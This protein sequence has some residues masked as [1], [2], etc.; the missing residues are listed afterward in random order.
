MA[1]HR[2]FSELTKNFSPERKR[3]IAAKTVEALAKMDR[4]IHIEP[5]LLDWSEWHPWLDIKRHAQQ[6]GVVVP[7]KQSGVYEVKIR[8]A[9]DRLAIGKSADLRMRIKQGLVC[10]KVGHPAGD[11]IR[12]RENVE[13][14]MVRWA[15]TDR[16]A[17]VEEE[18]HMR[19]EGRFGELPKYTHFT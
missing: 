13:D 17:A 18:L 4:E 15:I 2:K 5:I 9:E 16:P 1:G 14:V 7:N 10:G 3:W 8:G 19:H 11:K 12:S 6:G